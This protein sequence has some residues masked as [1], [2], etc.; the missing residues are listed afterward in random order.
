[1][2]IPV[3]GPLLK[4]CGAFFIR[5]S[6]NN[7]PMYS[8]IM[9]EYIELLLERGHNIEAFIEG[10]R[11]RMGKLLQPKFG[12]LKIILDSIVTNGRI[13]VLRFS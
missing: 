9:K 12:I 11:S 5:R 8:E 1:L 6:W 2:N 4:A 3:I 13:K 10:T 7:D